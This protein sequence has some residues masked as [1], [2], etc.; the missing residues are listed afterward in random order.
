MSGASSAFELL[1][2]VSALLR[3]LGLRW[4]L[5]GAQAAAVY[6]NPR[7][8]A[9]VDITIDRGP[10]VIEEIVHA[11]SGAGFTARIA[12][13][14]EF[15]ATAHVLPVIHEPTGMPLDIVLAGSGMEAE[16][17]ERL[18]RPRNLRVAS[19]PVPM[20]PEIAW[21]FSALR[22]QRSSVALGRMRA[23][24]SPL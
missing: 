12:D 15:L 20:I 2:D 13:P 18:A 10:M 5:F 17:L 1:H 3:R 6:G 21:R 4:Y 7:V 14:V 8:S 22:P 24:R 23:S 9:D 19:D 16:F 11:F